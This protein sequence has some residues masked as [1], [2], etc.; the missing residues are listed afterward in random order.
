MPALVKGVAEYAAAGCL[1]K[2]VLTQ[3]FQDPSVDFEFNLHLKRSGNRAPDG[4]F[5]ASTHPLMTHRELY[6]Y[7]TAPEKLPP[8]RMD[9][10]GWMATTMG[11]VTHG[12]IEAALE[13]MGVMVPLP[14]GD[15]PACGLPYKPPRAR[16]SAKW[17]MEH[18]AVDVPSR[19][20]CHLDGILNFGPQGTRGFDYKS[21]RPWGLKGIP[22]MDAEAFRAKWPGYWAQMQECM[23]MSGL[24]RY[25]VY[26]MEQGTPW[27]TREFHLDFDP[28]FAA[29]TEAKYL[30]VLDF[31]RRGV[32]IL[33]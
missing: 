21:I 23:R 10:V 28:V 13:R 30:E 32:E 22:D 19:S 5:H 11:T 3:F 31:V 25:I 26:F 4:W 24:R 1:V 27:D 9:Y 17:C 33:R 16:Q 6:L 15:C 18:G 8:R 2:P 7:L 12:V 29:Q 20:R 14:G